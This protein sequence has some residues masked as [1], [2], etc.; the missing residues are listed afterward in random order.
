MG[1][2]RNDRLNSTG[3]PAR[4]LRD[5]KG[6]IGQNKAE[7]AENFRVRKKSEKKK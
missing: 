3:D 2:S 7:K 4:D 5:S 1:S 6:R